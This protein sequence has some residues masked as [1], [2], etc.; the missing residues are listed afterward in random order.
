MKVFKKNLLKIEKGD[1]KTKK[2]QMVILRANHEVNFMLSFALGKV[3]TK[4]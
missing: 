4:N 2:A 3:T 1:I